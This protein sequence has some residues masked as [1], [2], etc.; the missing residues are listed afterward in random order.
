MATVVAA[1]TMVLIVMMLIM[2][3]TQEG[4]EKRIDFPF[5]FRN[6]AISRTHTDREKLVW[7]SGN[8]KDR[9]VSGSWKGPWAG[10]GGTQKPLRWP[11]RCPAA[12]AVTQVTYL[13]LC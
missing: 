10:L 5:P 2:S 8:L 13:S 3:S 9:G 4:K 6:A 11:A 1:V 12:A 7:Q